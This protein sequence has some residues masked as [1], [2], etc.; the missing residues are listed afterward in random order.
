MVFFAVAKDGRKLFRR[1][2]DN[3]GDVEVLADS[4]NPDPGADTS[5]FRDV[6]WVPRNLSADDYVTESFSGLSKTGVIET[7]PGIIY[8]QSGTPGDYAA[9][10][11]ADKHAG[12]LSCPMSR[13]S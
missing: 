2:L 9:Y 13:I 5:E 4:V 11:L 1:H 12:K 3:H 10:G 6:V 8:L 7:L